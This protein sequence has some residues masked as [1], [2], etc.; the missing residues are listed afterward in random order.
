MALKRSSE[1]CLKRLMHVYRYLLKAGHFPC[2]TCGGQFWPQCHNFNKLGSSL[3]DIATYQI[4]INALC[5]VVSDK[6]IVHV[7]PIIISPCKTCYPGEGLF[8]A[9]G[10]FIRT[11]L[12]EVY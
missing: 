2:D 1:F 5:H 9:P 8:L 12:T 10:A 7:V 3:V 6:K 4:S 11:N